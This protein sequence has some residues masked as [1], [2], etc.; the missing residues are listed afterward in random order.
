M[1]ID[2]QTEITVSAI[3]AP[4]RPNAVQFG[5]G[6]RLPS[7]PAPIRP[8]TVQFGGGYRLPMVNSAS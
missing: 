6:Y 3:A 4:V 1:I 5:G 7:I 8:G 2:L